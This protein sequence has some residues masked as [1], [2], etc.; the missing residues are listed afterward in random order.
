MR[1]AMSA[2]SCDERSTSPRALF[3]AAASS[4]VLCPLKLSLDCKKKISDRITTT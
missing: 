3:T 1:Y 4:K 2:I